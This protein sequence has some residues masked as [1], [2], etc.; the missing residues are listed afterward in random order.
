MM[1]TRSSSRAISGKF[2]KDVFEDPCIAQCIVKHLGQLHEDPSAIFASLKA[3]A[4]VSGDARFREA[5]EPAITFAGYRKWV[6]QWEDHSITIADKFRYQ[7]IG[8]TNSI[9]LIKLIQ[10]LDKVMSTHYKRMCDFMKSH[11]QLVLASGDVNDDMYQAIFRLVGTLPGFK[12]EGRLFIKEFY[13]LKAQ[14]WMKI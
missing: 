5:I 3:F 6:N 4:G 1:M 7:S 11:K 10:D 2:I 8:I 13:P 14:P 9:Y 12:D